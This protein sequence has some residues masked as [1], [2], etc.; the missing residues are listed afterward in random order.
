MDKFKLTDIVNFLLRDRHLYKTLP[1]KEKESN[2]FIINRFLS[3][4]YPE[5]AQKFNKKGVDKSLALDLWFLFLRHENKGD[6]YKWIWKKVPNEKRSLSAKDKTILMDKFELSG[7]D[8]EVLM[9]YHMDFLKEELK[10]YK[11]LIKETK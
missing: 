1:I 4:G 2:F 11:K 7:M 10:Y 8:L 3:K 5:Q 6:I 9:L